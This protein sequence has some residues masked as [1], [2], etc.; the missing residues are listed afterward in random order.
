MSAP[1]TLYV[2]VILSGSALRP[3]FGSVAGSYWSLR[4]RVRP[5]FGSLLSNLYGPVEIG[6]SLYFAPVSFACGT[7]AVDGSCAK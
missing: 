2:T 7:G 1:F 5:L 6:C 3:E 4:T